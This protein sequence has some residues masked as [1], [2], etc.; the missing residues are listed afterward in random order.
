[1]SGSTRA[2]ALARPVADAKDEVGAAHAV[3]VATAVVR[4]LGDLQDEQLRLPGLRSSRLRLGI[5][6]IPSL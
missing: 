5:C 1:M 3:A 4:L 2:G 6:R